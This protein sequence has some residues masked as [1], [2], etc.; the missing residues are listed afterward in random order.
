MSRLLKK[1]NEFWQQIIGFLN[2][3][4]IEIQ[5]KRKVTES[6]DKTIKVNNMFMIAL[7]ALILW[8][9]FTFYNFI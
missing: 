3:H 4:S 2:N 9:I 1:V 5:V 7:I 8:I 6:S